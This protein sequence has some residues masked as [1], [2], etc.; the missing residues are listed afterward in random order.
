MLHSIL[1]IALGITAAVAAILASRVWTQRQTTGAM[2]ISMFWLLAGAT[3]W[4]ILYALELSL[5]DPT[6]KI[7]VWHAKFLGIVVVPVTWFT[8]SVRYTGH[9]S[10]LPP[11]NL[12]ALFVVPILTTIIIWTNDSTHWM[13]TDVT[14]SAFGDLQLIDSTQGMWF[15]IHSVYSYTLIMGGA[16]LLLRRFL[17]SPSAYR[18]QLLALVIG[19]AAPLVANFITIFGGVTLDLTSFAFAITGAALTLGLLR[20]QLLDLVPV[21]REL[22][23]DS[24]SDAMLVLDNLDRIVDLNS[25]SEKL[26]GKTSSECVGKPVTSVL[27]ALTRQPA[28]VD[29]FRQSEPVLEEVEIARGEEKRNYD[30]RMSPL[31]D[32]NQHLTGRLIIIRDITERKKVEAKLQEQN[33]TL[34]RTNQELAI[35]RQE[36]ERA[37]ELKSQFLANM[38]HELRTPLNAIIGYT[39]IQLAGMTGELTEEQNKYQERILA[40]AENL[41]TLINDVLDISKIEAGMMTLV[42]K[43]FY[44]RDWLTEVVSQIRVLAD[45]K[46]LQLQVDADSKLPEN[47]VEDSERL[48]QV[49]INLLSNAV[50]FTETGTIRVALTRDSETTWKIVVKDTGIGIPAHAHETIFEEFRQVDG[51]SRRQYGGTGLGLAIVRRFVLMMGG[52]IQLESEVG[53]GSTFTVSLPLTAA[54]LPSVPTSA[55]EVMGTTRN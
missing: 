21:A 50:K 34:I 15:W 25:A 38:S 41:L 3:W 9:D 42:R 35:A 6:L 1:L 49:V 48:K 26:I 40:N 45:A 30:V 27:N 44:L 37:T 5:S 54:T 46:G 33:E 10:W 23:I 52:T 4:T 14:V 32:R 36:A 17:V 53:T 29:K 31:R 43:S 18:R 39:E 24:M 51:S 55:A 8:F 13:W 20:Y 11:R 2:A 12:A 28:L 7:T 16:Y 19:V 22:V 47:L